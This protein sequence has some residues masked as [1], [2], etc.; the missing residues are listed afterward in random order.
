MPAKQQK[1]TKTRRQQHEEPK[2]EATEVLRTLNDQ[3]SFYFY[4]AIGKPTGENASSLID[5]L[6]KIKSVKLGSILF[7]LPRKDFQNWTRKILGDPKLATRIARI[8]I[9]HDESVRA[10]V[11][12]IIEDRIRELRPTSPTTL[13]IENLTVSSEICAQ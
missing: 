7:H 8:P 4:E 12:A 10:K 6:E 5:F 9:S 13:T 3:E 11:H 2:P 1:K